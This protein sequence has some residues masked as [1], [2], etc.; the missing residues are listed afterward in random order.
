M[1]TKAIVEYEWA[2]EY[3]SYWGSDGSPFTVFDEEILPLGEM[4]VRDPEKFYSE[5]LR[6]EL[7]KDDTPFLN[8][9]YVVEKME[10][11]KSYLRVNVYKG[12]YP[13]GREPLCVVD[14][15]PDVEHSIIYKKGEGE[16]VDDAV[17]DIQDALQNA[18]Y[19]VFIFCH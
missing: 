13:A 14:F 12:K 7:V 8:Y 3:A 19:S 6:L 18:G 16:D 1:T 9:V 15:I 11:E 4:A 10:G 17:R 2:R 5:F